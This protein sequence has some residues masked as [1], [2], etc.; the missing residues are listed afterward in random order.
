MMKILIS[1]PP[2]CGKTTLLS[3]V[4][5]NF[6]RE[7]DSVFAGGFLCFEKVN[8]SG[9]REAFT[10]KTATG[11][12]GEFMRKMEQFTNAVSTE[13]VSWSS[14][15]W[16]GKYR[17]NVDV[18]EQVMCSEL[19]RCV[20]AN[21]SLVYIDEI[22]RAQASSKRFI[23]GIQTLFAS[24]IPIIA[25]IVQ[26]DYDWNIVFKRDRNVF[27]ITVDDKN[28]DYL[29]TVICAALRH[30]NLYKNL[31]IA[32]QQLTREMFSALIRDSQFVNAIKLFKNALRY[33]LEQ[34]VV[35][36]GNID[37]DEDRLIRYKV[38]GITGT[39]IVRLSKDGAITLLLHGAHRDVNMCDCPLFLGSNMFSDCKPG[40]LCSHIMCVMLTIADDSTVCC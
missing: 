20:T 11:E 12:S 39:H 27:L 28:R 1:G 21:P 6:A 38:T 40:G 17:V 34:R 10:V 31:S 2:G 29:E 23:E 32:Q 13:L 37:G 15:F 9:K 8:E 26:E 30:A 7:N 35:K 25:S 4:V 14:D 33:T 22:G 36:L 18:I 3:A 5:E 24:E 16:V 19:E